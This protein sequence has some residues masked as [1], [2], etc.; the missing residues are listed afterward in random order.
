MDT[1]TFRDNPG[2]QVAL[3]IACSAVG[4]VLIVSL[5]GAAGQVGTNEF[6]GFLLGVLLLAIGLVPLVLRG[7]QT[8]VIEPR[9]RQIV[10]DDTNLLG[11]R[12]RTIPFAEI[13]DIRIGY[14][15]R[16]STHVTFY[17]LL[18]MLK[19]GEEYPLFGPGR[20]YEGSTVRATMEKHRERLLE[21]INHPGRSGQA[22]LP[23]FSSV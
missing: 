13:S 19:S 16:K 6:A 12:R 8:I 15:G 10:V 17:Y 3:A 23:P 18:L 21:L 2:K 11:S 22:G 9:T 20:F 5:R 14:L 7:R 4:L 1:M